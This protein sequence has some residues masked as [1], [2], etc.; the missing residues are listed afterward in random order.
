MLGMA[1]LPCRNR[2]DGIPCPVP[3]APFLARQHAP[4][5]SR[6]STS[7]HRMMLVEETRQLCSCSAS[8]EDTDAETVQDRGEICPIS[9]VVGATVCLNR[10]ECSL[11]AHSCTAQGPAACLSRPCACCRHS[12][13]RA[14]AAWPA[15]PAARL[16]PGPR[17]AHGAAEIPAAGR[18]RAAGRLCC[19]LLLFAA[20]C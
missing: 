5:C 16:G 10:H 20:A 2:T 11:Q 8:K 18:R 9:A 3:S 7:M 4:R 15:R 13:L 17:G 6:R 14:G 12:S 19:E 1:G